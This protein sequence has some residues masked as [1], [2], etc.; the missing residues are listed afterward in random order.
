MVQNNLANGTLAETLSGVTRRQ[1]VSP[2]LAINHCHRCHL[3]SATGLDQLSS[4]TP[5]LKWGRQSW[6]Q[7]V[8]VTAHRVTCRKALNPSPDPQ[9]ALAVHPTS[10][11]PKGHSGIRGGRSPRSGNGHHEKEW[12]WQQNHESLEPV[13][14]KWVQSKWAEGRC[15]Y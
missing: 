3:T 6:P 7:R 10:Q 9:Q 2:V 8:A 13:L 1:L 4:W 11:P 14:A 12:H 5:S 15:N